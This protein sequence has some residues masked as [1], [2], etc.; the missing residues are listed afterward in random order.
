MQQKKFNPE[1]LN[2]LNDPKRLIEIPPAYIWQKVGLTQPEVM[3]DIG[4]GTAFFSVAFLALAE[5]SRIYAIDESDVLLAWVRENVCP[6]HPGIIPQKAENN[7][8]LL[9]DE[10][11]DLTYMINLHH[12]LDDPEAMLRESYRITKRAGRLFIVDWKKEETTSGPPLTIRYRPEEIKAQLETAG[13]GNVKVFND[14]PK[15]FLII[16]DK[17]Q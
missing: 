6:R 10:T 15:Q 9:P 7:T 4:A 1:H 11:A 8:I 16:A 12:E 17:G 3:V 5:K 14:L 13:F 2:K